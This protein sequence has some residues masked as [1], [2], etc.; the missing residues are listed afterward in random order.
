MDFVAATEARKIARRMTSERGSQGALLGVSALVFSASVALTIAWCTSMSAMGEMAMPGGWTMSMVWMRMPGQT[1]IG[2][3]AAFVAMWS[4]MMAA[5]MLPSLV[6]ML[7]R[8]GDAVGGAGEARVGQLTTLVGVGYFMV[9]T[10][11]GMAVFPLGIT[12]A[13]VAM[14][15]S[16]LARYFPIAVGVVVAMA[17]ILQLSAWKT[18]HLACCCE[19]PG[20]GRPL[21]AEA[22]MAWRH[23]LRLGVH[24]VYCSVPL[25]ATLL[26]LGV[27][28][29]RVM[30]VVAAAI[31]LERFARDGKRVAR[32]IGVV[33]V[34][35]GLFLIARAAGLG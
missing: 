19:S 15:H 24:C 31:T 11:L 2:A 8:Y 14:E 18:R 17:G 21:S 34:G 26:S 29:L 27:M 22:G 5:M 25:M 23:G 4:L 6:P 12:L 30:A 7:F 1:W 33:A 9:W 20:R 32:V 28:D 10:V 3:A 35:E 16:A 13:S